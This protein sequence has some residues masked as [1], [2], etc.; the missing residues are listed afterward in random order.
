MLA[1]AKEIRKVEPLP[2]AFSA[3]GQHT[4]IMFNTDV[5]LNQAQLIANLLLDIREDVIGLLFNRHV[6]RVHQ[7]IAR[8]N[9][10]LQGSARGIFCEWAQIVYTQA[11]A[12]GVRRLASDSYED[13]DANLVRFLDLLIRDPKSL[14]E[15][16]D[17]HFAADANKARDQV[18]KEAGGLGPGWEIRACKR[19]L[20]EDRKV[21]INAA[22]KTNR[23]ATKRVA[24]SVPHVEVRTTFSDLD[25]AI[26]VLKKLTEKYTLL[27]CSRER[28]RLEPR[29]RAGVPTVYPVLVRLER[30]NP[31][32]LEEMKSRKLHKGWD[33]IFLETWATT[34]TIALQLGEMLPP[35]QD[36][37]RS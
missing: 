30:H 12:A 11:N 10:R 24:H 17:R 21:V 33:M 16:F 7:E 3:G 32:L 22:K 31:D 18:S 1:N 26:D 2:V 37:S 15:S 5:T 4:E 36:R 34:E 28:E 25:E 6:F 35:R 19:L 9:P 8:R 29:H 20:S 23:F 27:L 13:G 14:W